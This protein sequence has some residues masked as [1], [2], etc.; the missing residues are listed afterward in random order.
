MQV[1]SEVFRVFSSE[2][3]QFL[4]DRSAWKMFMHFG[5]DSFPP[6]DGGVHQIFGKRFA[7]H[8]GAE[9]LDSIHSIEN[10]RAM[11][12]VKIKNLVRVDMFKDYFM[13]A[14]LV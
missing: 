12:V 2:G 9:V 3:L 8:S 10:E 5:S 14:G 4:V 13:C 11:S 7:V 1:I 6:S